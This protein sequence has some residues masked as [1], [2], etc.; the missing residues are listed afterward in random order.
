MGYKFALLWGEAQLCL[1]YVT[2]SDPRVTFSDPKM[3][4]SYPKVTYCD[5]KMTYS[6]P[7]V[8]YSDPKITYWSLRWPIVTLHTSLYLHLPHLTTAWLLVKLN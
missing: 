2:Y 7:K 6:D 1:P 8:T 3:T 4:Y 5:H